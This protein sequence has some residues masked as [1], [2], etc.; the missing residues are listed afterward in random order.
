MVHVS[1]KRELKAQEH[2]QRCTI[3]DAKRLSFRDQVSFLVDLVLVTCEKSS[4]NYVRVRMWQLEQA[5]RLLTLVCSVLRVLRISLPDLATSHNEKEGELWS[6]QVPTRSK[7][8]VL[9]LSVT[10]S[11]LSGQQWL[12]AQGWAPGFSVVFNSLCARVGAS[13]YWQLHSNSRH[14]LGYVFVWCW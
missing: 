5:D 11:E 9:K 8:P 6:V 1:R 4:A 10:A 12:W 13:G 7:V 14:S 3:L 2:T